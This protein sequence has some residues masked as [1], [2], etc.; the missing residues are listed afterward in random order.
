MESA[1]KNVRNLQR[2]LIEETGQNMKSLIG[3]QQYIECTQLRKR[4]DKKTLCV[5]DAKDNIHQR[6]FLNE[7]YHK[8][9]KR[10][11]NTSMQGK[12]N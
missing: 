11:H 6:K 10:G 5:T 4:G 1:N 12:T 7:L 2:L 8:C 3:V 9:G